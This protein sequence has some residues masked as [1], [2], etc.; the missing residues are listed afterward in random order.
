MLLT[1]KYAR[2]KIDPLFHQENVY[3]GFYG[4]EYSGKEII[5]PHKTL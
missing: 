5:N 1:D 2:H 3:V 4:N